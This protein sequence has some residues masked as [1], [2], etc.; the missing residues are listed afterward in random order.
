MASSRGKVFEALKEYTKKQLDFDARFDK[1]VNEQDKLKNLNVNYGGSFSRYIK[2]KFDEFRKIDSISDAELLNTSTEKWEK[3]K[4]VSKPWS[5]LK[6]IGENVFDFIVGDIVEV[7]SLSALLDIGQQSTLLSARPM[8]LSLLLLPI[9][10]SNLS[11]KTGSAC[12]ELPRTHMKPIK[13]SM[14]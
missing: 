9:A 4:R 6:G 1:R 14:Y 5:D 7:L 13:H 3:F 8:L 2:A 11:L 10:T 12:T